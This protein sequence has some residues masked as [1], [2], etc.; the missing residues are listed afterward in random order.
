MDFLTIKLAYYRLLKKYHSM[1]QE[2]YIE[3]K[4]LS[5]LSSSPFHKN[6]NPNKHQACIKSSEFLEKTLITLLKV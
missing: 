5:I 3:M 4:R 2:L 1:K 6:Q